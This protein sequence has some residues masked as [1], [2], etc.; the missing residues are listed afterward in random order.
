MRFGELCHFPLN[1][2]SVPEFFKT[3]RFHP[4]SHKISTFEASCK[5][6]TYAVLPRVD[7]EIEH[8]MCRGGIC[9]H[10]VTLSP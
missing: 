5:A 7:D 6:A 10:G 3:C 9:W 8:E 4:I 1:F 2:F